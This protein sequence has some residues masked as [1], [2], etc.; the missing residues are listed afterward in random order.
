MK[1]SKNFTTV[2]P[3]STA[4]AIILFILLPCI[5]FYIGIQYQ[6]NQDDILKA[7]FQNSGYIE[8]TK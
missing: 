3:F 1:I 5:G 2:T 8:N 6:K 7:V 4:L